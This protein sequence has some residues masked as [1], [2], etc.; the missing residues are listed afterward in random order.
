M[1]GMTATW[2]KSIFGSNPITSCRRQKFGRNCATIRTSP[3][4]SSSGGL[5]CIPARIIPLPRARCIRPMAAKFLTSTPGPSLCAPKLNRT[6]ANFLSQ[7]FGVLP[8]ESILLEDQLKDPGSLFNFTCSL[9]DIVKKHMAFGE[10]DF[11]WA[12]CAN[13]AIA[14]Y[15][16]LV[17][18]CTNQR[19]FPDRTEP[20]RG[21]PGSGDPAACDNAAGADRP[22]QREGIPGF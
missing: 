20:V 5:I 2:P 22:A 19:N 10:G 12:T 3:A 13:T 17:F 16:R 7:P 4:P 9:I 15:Y 1:A 18:Q 11:S 21:G 8:L 14:T 6:W